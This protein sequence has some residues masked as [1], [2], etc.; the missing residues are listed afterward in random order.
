MLGLR[1]VRYT[2]VFLVDGN[3]FPL[4]PWFSLSSIFQGKKDTFDL[5]V[6]G[7]V[8][9]TIINGLIHVIPPLLLRGKITL[10]KNVFRLSPISPRSSLY[11]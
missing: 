2:S 7:H 3:A 11:C 9:A 4:P 1:S 10:F 8:C 5:I 6:F